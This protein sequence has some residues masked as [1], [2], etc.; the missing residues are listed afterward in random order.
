MIEERGQVVAVERDRIRILV[1]R[2]SS[3][4]SCQARAACGQGLSEALRPGRS[5]EL[6]VQCDLP[7]AV[8][9]QVVVGVAANWIVRGAMLVYLL[10]LL[11]LLAGAILAERSGLGEGWSILLALLGFAGTVLGLYVYNRKLAAEGKLLPSVLRVEPQLS[12][13]DIIRWEP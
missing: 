2:S 6:Q 3:C 10:P 8:G 7:V 9:D 12:A 4:G 13:A 11:A 5:H 1:E